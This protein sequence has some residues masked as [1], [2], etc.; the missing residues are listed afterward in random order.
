[1]GRST[2]RILLTEIM[3]NILNN[4]VVVA[5]LERDNAI[6]LEAALSF[7]GLGVQPPFLPGA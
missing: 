2:W 7:L 1:M 5:T 4:L 6:L 3:P